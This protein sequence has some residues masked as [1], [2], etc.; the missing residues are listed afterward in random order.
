MSFEWL[1]HVYIRHMIQDKHGRPTAATTH[2][3]TK[4]TTFFTSLAQSLALRWLGAMWW[5]QKGRLV[6]VFMLLAIGAVLCALQAVRAPRLLQAAFWLAGTSALV[7]VL[8]YNLGARQVA[9]VEL[10]VGA[11]LV[12]ILF[13][14]AIS[15]AGEPAQ[16]GR[17][18]VPVPL[19]VA[20]VGLVFVL[21]VELAWP[22]IEAH[23][24][25][26][27]AP[28]SEVLWQDRQL[29]VLVQI[30]L[31]FT[32]ALTIMGLF[33]DDAPATKATRANEWLRSFAGA[34]ET[35]A[36][37]DPLANRPL[38]AATLQSVCAG[39]PMADPAAWHE[40]SIA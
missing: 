28:L 6:V 20:V 29:D 9:V 3:S 2:T 39:E 34:S 25:A 18:L 22:S 38:S 30:V 17:A 11:G 33:A 8:L 10:S 32:A 5:R 19:A 35:P 21:L 31:I 26:L 24:V 1:T 40:E 14:F 37:L 12:I 7:S 4:G 36:R 27:A 23:A 13:V 16:S 15:L